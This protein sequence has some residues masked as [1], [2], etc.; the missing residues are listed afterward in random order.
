[1]NTSIAFCH[2]NTGLNV[3]LAFSA[4]N[5]V[6]NFYCFYLLTASLT[7]SSTISILI[8]SQGLLRIPCDLSLQN[9]ERSL[10][11][12]LFSAAVLATSQDTDLAGLLRDSIT[13]RVSSTGGRQNLKR[14]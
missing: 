12:R 9:L 1:M 11:A 2:R 8:G 5:T 7:P 10:T 4:N 6:F 13:S 14:G 3:S